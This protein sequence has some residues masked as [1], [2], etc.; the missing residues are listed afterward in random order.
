[1]SLGFDG[2]NI[3]LAGDGMMEQ[4]EILATEVLGLPA[5]GGPA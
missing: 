4:M 5:S 1:L 2:V 3:V